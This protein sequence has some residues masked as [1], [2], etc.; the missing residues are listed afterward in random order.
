[1]DL[2]LVERLIVIQEKKKKYLRPDSVLLIEEPLWGNRTHQLTQQ[3]R[4]LSGLL[5]TLL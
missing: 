1:M 4:V 5:C 2:L 3:L